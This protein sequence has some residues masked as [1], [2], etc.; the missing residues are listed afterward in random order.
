MLNAR[1]EHEMVIFQWP[2]KT[3]PHG[4]LNA[5]SMLVKPE[6]VDR[7]IHRMCTTQKALYD[8]NKA[9][10]A[11]YDKNQD[12]MTH[13]E[14]LL[15]SA[16]IYFLDIGLLGVIQHQAR[17][18]TA[19]STTEAESISP[20]QMLA[21]SLDAISTTTDYGFAFNKIRCIVTIKVLLL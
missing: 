11:W 4:D 12:V 14:V 10:R 19:I 1:D 13:G 3:A 15:G 8:S 7:R 5:L 9:L 18:V 21:K 2:W 6:V 20:L 17:Q 16:Q